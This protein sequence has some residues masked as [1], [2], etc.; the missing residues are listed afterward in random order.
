[1]HF[2]FSLLRIK[3]LYMFRALLAHPQ[4]SLHK[5]HLVYCVRVMSVSCTIIEVE[6]PTDIT[7]T[8]YTKCRLYSTS[9]GWA[10]DIRNIYRS[11]ILN[12]LNK[13]YITLVL[14]CWCMV[15]ETLSNYITFKFQCNN[16]NVYL[17]GVKMLLA[18]LNSRPG[19]RRNTLCLSYKCM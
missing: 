12:K 18:P 1:M 3:G 8:Q 11:L 2:L 14:L 10:S 17:M 5:G 15:K 9:W 13:K 6:Q 19:F 4:G 7:R 16:Y